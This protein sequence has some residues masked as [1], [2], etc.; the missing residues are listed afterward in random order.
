MF[1]VAKCLSP[2]F[3]IIEDIDRITEPIAQQFADRLA[4]LTPVCLTKLFFEFFNFV[5]HCILF[6]ISKHVPLQ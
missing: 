2:S 3:L 6:L 4:S 1:D 5:S